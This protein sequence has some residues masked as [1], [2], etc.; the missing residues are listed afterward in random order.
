MD[1]AELAFEDHSKN[2]TVKRSENAG[3]QGISSSQ[4]YEAQRIHEEMVGSLNPE[5]K[6]L[7]EFD[8]NGG[9]KIGH[10]HFQPPTARFDSFSVHYEWDIVSNP[11]FHGLLDAR[12]P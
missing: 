4:Y 9:F 2:L 1:D 11:V 6:Y 5:H 12:I 3:R 7:S 8:E 10:Y